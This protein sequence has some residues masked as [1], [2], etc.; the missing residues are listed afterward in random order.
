MSYQRVFKCRSYL[1]INTC[2]CVMWLVEMFCD[3]SV[4][5]CNRIN[6]FM[7]RWCILRVVRL[8]ARGGSPQL[9]SL[10][11]LRSGTSR[12]R[13]V[14]NWFCN[15]GRYSG[16]FS[17]KERVIKAVTHTPT[18]KKIQ[19]ICMYFYNQLFCGFRVK[20]RDYRHTILRNQL[21]LMQECAKNICTH[22]GHFQS[23][24]DI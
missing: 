17:W 15:G 14:S 10:R 16:L 13:A 18:A 2:L 4:R 21:M 6:L 5:N 20:N 7:S 19:L 8:A 23:L 24:T 3:H 12:H 11:D 9:T 22:Y 1:F